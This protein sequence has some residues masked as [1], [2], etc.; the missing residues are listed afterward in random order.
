[1]QTKVIRCFCGIGLNVNNTASKFRCTRCGYIHEYA[2]ILDKPTPKQIRGY[3]GRGY[4][5]NRIRKERLNYD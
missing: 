5:I 4:K 3:L 2:E 1:M